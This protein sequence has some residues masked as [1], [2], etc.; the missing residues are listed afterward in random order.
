LL[1][2]DTV[3]QAHIVGAGREKAPVHSV[4]TEVA[5]PGDGMVAVKGNGIVGTCLDTQ[6]AAAAPGLIQQDNII[7][8]LGNGRFR[9][10]FRTG[11]VVT[12]AADM[13]MIKEVLLPLL[14][15]GPGL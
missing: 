5:F 15:P 8:P 10:G 4:V 11:W 2:V 1:Q 7:L 12:V 13:N 9:A 3:G 6:S 14:G